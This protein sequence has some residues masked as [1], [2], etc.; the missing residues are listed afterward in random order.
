MCS[1]LGIKQRYSEETWKAGMVFVTESQYLA[2][3]PQ[4]RQGQKQTHLS[5]KTLYLKICIYGNKVP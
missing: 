3:I 4:L 1:C 2:Y 5:L